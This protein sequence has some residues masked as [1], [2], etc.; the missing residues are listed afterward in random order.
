MTTS[1]DCLW[2]WLITGGA[3]AAAWLVMR[4][5]E[6]LSRNIGRICLGCGFEFY[7]SDDCPNCTGHTGRPAALKPDLSGIG[8]G[9]TARC[10]SGR[11]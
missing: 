3:L 5:A 11:G 1:W 7:G 4:A 8:P 10:G 9:G 6:R 2:P